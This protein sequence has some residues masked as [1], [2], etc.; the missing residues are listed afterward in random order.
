[1]VTCLSNI[2]LYKVHVKCIHSLVNGHLCSLHILAILGTFVYSFLHG[3]NF[4]F[5]KMI[6]MSRNAG[7]HDKLC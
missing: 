2:L 6:T 7:L 3:H 5:M 4:I 1:M